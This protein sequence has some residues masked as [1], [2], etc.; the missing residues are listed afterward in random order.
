MPE[1]A[2]QGGDYGFTLNRSHKKT[3]TLQGGLV[4]AE[5]GLGGAGWW[6]WVDYAT[7]ASRAAQVWVRRRS[8]KRVGHAKTHVLCGGNVGVLATS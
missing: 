1:P 5:G 8:T 3:V 2:V 4:G 7:A 6:D